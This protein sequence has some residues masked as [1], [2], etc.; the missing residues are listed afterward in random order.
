MANI[1]EDKGFTYGIGS[2]VLANLSS[3]IFLIATEVNVDSTNATIKEISKEMDKLKTE[4]VSASELNRVK[5]FM[6]G[7]FLRSSDGP[8]NVADKFKSSYLH[9]LGDKF[10]G[11][12]LASIEEVTSENIRDLAL[13]YLND[14]EMIQVVVGNR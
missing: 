4:K 5:K 3:T 14:N 9:D 2:G 10:N 7:S 6:V 11:Q 12:Y 13:K 1:R 8:F